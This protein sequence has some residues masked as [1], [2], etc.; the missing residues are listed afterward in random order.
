MIRYCALIFHE[1]IG[2]LF[3]D[4]AAGERGGHGPGMDLL[5]REILVDE[6]DLREFSLD[7]LPVELL[8]LVQFG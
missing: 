2:G 3:V 7:S 1:C 6:A 8:P 5:E 4:A